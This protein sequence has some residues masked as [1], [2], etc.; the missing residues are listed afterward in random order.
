MRPAKKNLLSFW[1][2]KS[3]KKA[4]STRPHLSL[5]P[6]EPRQMMSVSPVPWNA[7][8]PYTSICQ[9]T[10]TFPNGH[11]QGVSGV[12]IDRTHVLTA[13]HAVYDYCYGGWAT[14]LTVAP[15]RNNNY[16]RY[17]SAYVTHE[18]T[19]NAWINWSNTHTDGSSW[20]CAY[21]IGMLTLSKPLGAYTGW[22]G[23]G[24]EPDSFFSAGTILNTAGYPTPAPFNG[25][26]MYASSGA[27][28]GLSGDDMG[29]L[30]TNSAITFYHGDSGSPLFAYWPSKNAFQIVGICDGTLTGSWNFATR[31]TT[32]IFNTIRGWENSSATVA[33]AS[34]SS[35]VVSATA[36]PIISQTS[37]LTATAGLPSKC[38]YDAALTELLMEST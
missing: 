12:I 26:Q 17:G 5:E 24:T 34:V 9:I 35:T 6:L 14:S 10:E 2:G 36:P 22:M 16:F 25:L 11:Q 1:F 8:F 4:R 31:F 13:G 27:I 21:D 19:F 18:A 28:A 23:F 20:T 33:N 7:G 15:E 30:F 32:T 38:F 29:I 37:T 3:K